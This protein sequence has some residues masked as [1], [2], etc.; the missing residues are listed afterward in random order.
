MNRLM[1]LLLWIG[2]AMP[3]C[4][5][6]PERPP[7]FLVIVADD[8]GF[9]DLGCYGG[10]IAT[11]NLDRLAA[12]GLRFTRFYN[13][14]RCWPT[15][16]SILTGYYAQQVRMDPPKGRLPAFARLLP[17]H[18][19]P[20]GYRS[21]HS[22]KWHVMGAPNI[23]ADGGFDRSYDAADQ[24]RFFSP[25]RY[26]R[27]DQPLPPVE[28]DSG[29]YST[30]AIAEMAI[31]HLKE[32]A[33]QHAGRPFFQ[34]LAFIAP[35][36]PLHALQEDIDKYRDRYRVGWDVIRRERHERLKRLGIATHPLPPLEPDVVPNWNLPPEALAGRIGPGEAPQAVPWDEL[37]QEQKDF[38]AT[39]MAIHAAMVDRMDREIG[40]VLDQLRAMGELDNTVILFVSD[41][42][43]SAEQIIRGDGHDPSAPP[44]SART[45]LCLGPG[46]STAANTPLRKHKH[47]THEGGIA[48][49][50]I[51]HWP[52][53][54]KNPG[55]LRHAPG[56]V[57][58]ILPT[59][60]DL[61]GAG[62]VH[63]ADSVSTP[64][65]GTPPRPGRSLVPA[66]GRRQ[67]VQRDYL[68]FH[69]Q[70]NRALIQDH[71]KLVSSSD[72]PSAWELY[73]LSRDRGEMTDLAAEQ[74]GRVRQMA[75]QWQALDASYRADGQMN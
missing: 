54:I 30:T 49:P 70:G 57:I 62:G 41:N 51:V 60:L 74:P 56:H 42:G 64:V 55:Q 16:A 36:F 52:G 72:N 48:T 24:D 26:R 65:D 38:Q 8:L 17:H 68:Y 9:S 6:A 69:H 37:S 19:N 40:R 25:N 2:A 32:H 35:H 44:G 39:K 59:L 15:R 11:P 1:M 63:D 43:A 22:G 14:G 47:W 21:Y 67:S 50:L 58:D 3:G 75:E 53:R 31:Q 18:L 27:D 66:F 61:A 46:W 23:I 45:Y 28:P 10:E 13:T 12:G 20:L 73:D 33:E 29:F 7:N 71:W 4:Q 34:Y 5:T